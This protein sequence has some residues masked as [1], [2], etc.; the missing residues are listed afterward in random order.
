MTTKFFAL[1]PLIYFGLTTGRAA[2]ESP[3][4]TPSPTVEAS[5]SLPEDEN[6]RQQDPSLV[7]LLA[8]GFVTK[9]PSEWAEY[10]SAFNLLDERLSSKWATKRGVISPQTIVIALAEKTLLK[11]LEFSSASVDSQFTG[12]SAKDI[13]VEMSD[14]SA[15]DGFQKIAEVSLKD[16]QDNQRFPVSAEVPGRWV[17]LTVKNNHSSDPDNTI[18]LAEFRGFG[19]QITHTPFADVSGTYDGSDYTGPLHIKQDGTSVAGCYESR[20]GR[21]DGGVDGRVVTLTWHDNTGGNPGPGTAV[22]VFAPDRKQFFSLWWGP[23]DSSMYGKLS[24]GPKKSDE[25]GTCPQWVKAMK[26]EPVVEQTTPEPTTPEPTTKPVIPK[27]TSEPATPEP[28]SETPTPAAKI[29]SVV[30]KPKPVTVV[31]AQM[32]QDLEDYGR[33]RVYGIHFDSDSDHIKDESKPTLDSIVAMLRKRADWKMSIEGHTDSTS[34]PEHN[35]GLSERRAA[36]VKNYLTTAGIDGSRL[37]TVGYGQ[38]KPVAP[39]DNP[40]GK[41]QNRRV[42]LAKQ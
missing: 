13:T 5:A 20:E 32:T 22:I 11:T 19:T 28:K 17:R 38:D 25:V 3:S 2:E 39:N 40:I 6:A 30:E 27:P 34:T 29:E 18:E 41:A 10:E 37:S 24:L 36:S 23:Y 15:E 9:R 26:S 33:V 7:S 35:Q 21:F 16:R 31:Q 4:P 12:C 14:T 8:G 1:V 42:E